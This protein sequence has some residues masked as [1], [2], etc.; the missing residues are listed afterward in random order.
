MLET[1]TALQ[2][3]AVGALGLV[4]KNS[5]NLFVAGFESGSALIKGANS[6]GVKM[7]TASGSDRFTLLLILNTFRVTGLLIPPTI[8]TISTVGGVS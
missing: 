5:T 2:T 8:G 3:L 6:S 1:A 7:A 4:D